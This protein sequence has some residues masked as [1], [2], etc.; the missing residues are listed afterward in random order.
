MNRFLLVL[1]FVALAFGQTACGQASSEP[2]PA[3]RKAR[4]LANLVFEF[5][6][7]GQYRVDIG[8]IEPTAIAGLSKGSFTINGASSA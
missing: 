5:P 7:L 4:I 1:T 3:E 2:T 6:Q 8:D